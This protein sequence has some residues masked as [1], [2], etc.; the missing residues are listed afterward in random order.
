MKTPRQMAL[1]LERT[2]GPD[3]EA[4]LAAWSDEIRVGEREDCAAVADEQC[5][6]CGYAIRCSEDGADSDAAVEKLRDEVERGRPIRADER[7]RI[8][9][10]VEETGGL[11]GPATA[12]VWEGIAQ[13]VRDGGGSTK[14]YD[15]GSECRRIYDGSRLRGRPAQR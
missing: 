7:A 15:A 2:N 6:A 13:E 12:S 9:A 8:A 3:V 10:W 5:P 11:F 1:E 4:V 14:H